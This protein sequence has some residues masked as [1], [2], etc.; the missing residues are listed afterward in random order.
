MH[1]RSNAAGTFATG[2]QPRLLSATRVTFEA[3]SVS[4]G[5]TQATFAAA[6]FGVAPGLHFTVIVVRGPLGT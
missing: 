1:R 5:L 4:S 2:C 6:G 3:T